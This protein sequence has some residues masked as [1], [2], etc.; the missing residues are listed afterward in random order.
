M[1]SNNEY[2]IQ[3][4]IISYSAKNATQK[5][6]GE[7]I[8]QYLYRLAINNEAEGYLERDKI[9]RAALVEL[10]NYSFNLFED[11]STSH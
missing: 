9:L 8:L 7:E 3:K 10:S 2:N 11:F 4:C 6:W 1:L 5:I